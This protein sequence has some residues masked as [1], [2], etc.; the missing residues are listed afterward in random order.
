MADEID[1]LAAAMATLAES[2]V[3]KMQ[4]IFQMGMEKSQAL[5]DE[6]LT[7]IKNNTG[8]RSAVLDKAL[9]ALGITEPK[10]DAEAAARN[11]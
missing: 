11:V 1:P 5:C 4:E 8:R 6:T 7:S 9:A 10:S 2:H 3:N